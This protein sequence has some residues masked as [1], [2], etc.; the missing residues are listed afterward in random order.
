MILSILEH[1]L[2]DLISRR[3]LR[4]WKS[5]RLLIYIRYAASHNT[6]TE[7]TVKRKLVWVNPRFVQNSDATYKCL[8]LFEAM[9]RIWR[10]G[11]KWSRSNQW[12]ETVVITVV[13]TVEYHGSWSLCRD[14]G[15]RCIILRVGKAESLKNSCL[16]ATVLIVKGNT[17]RWF[18]VTHSWNIV[19]WIN[20]TTSIRLLFG[21]LCRKFY[22]QFEE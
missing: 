4:I 7:S 10:V 12:Q 5:S 3:G 17:T 14:W 13:R 16:R 21:Q 8:C 15:A 6:N 22:F 1:H 9:S 18:Q 19:I 11:W 20:E 2:T